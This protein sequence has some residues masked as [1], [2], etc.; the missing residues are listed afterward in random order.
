MAGHWTDRF[1][2]VR[3]AVRYKDLAYLALV[4]DQ[5]VKAKT[6]HTMVVEWDGGEWN[7]GGG[8]GWLLAGV[9]IARQ[10]LEQLLAAGEYG[11]VVVLGSGDRHEEQIGDEDSSPRSRGPLRGV[12]NIGRRVYAVG[13]NRQVYRRENAHRWISFDE[14]ARPPEGSQR[15][16]GFE[17]IDGFSESE[18]YA[19]G[20]EGEVWYY[21]GKRWRDIKSPTNLLLFDVCCAGDGNA[22]ACGQVGTILR[23]RRGEWEVLRQ[24]DVTDDLWSCAWFEGELYVSSM[25]T[26]YK[27]RGENLELV[28]MGEDI[29]QT[30]FHLSS[31]DGVLWSIGAKDVFA[32]NGRAW[33]RID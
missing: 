22:Y 8:G 1:S 14:G 33:T 32:Y 20:W 11:D 25:D 27:L 15:V 23:G 18:M 31:A 19:V 4:D 29:P 7:D 21:T 24:E 3:G 9:T 12:R 2:F 13:M 30:C 10:P 5:L 17:A 28:D 6:P 26:L 16:V